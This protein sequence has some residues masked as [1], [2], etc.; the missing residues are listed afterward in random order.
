MSVTVYDCDGCG[1]P[2]VSNLVHEC[3][4]SQERIRVIRSRNNRR[5]HRMESGTGFEPRSARSRA[6]A[7]RAYRIL[8]EQ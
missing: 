2:I 5:A 1:D 8:N 7:T 6:M 3:T 4:D